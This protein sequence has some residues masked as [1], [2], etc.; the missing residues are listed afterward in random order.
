VLS[1]VRRNFRTKLFALVLAI[2]A[3]A[4][5]HFSAS[6]SI[7]AHFEQQ[8]SVP[9]VVSGLR[10]GFVARYTDKIALV[11]IDVPRNGPAIKPEEVQAVL[12]VNAH[13]EA[14]IFNVPVEIIAPNLQIRSLSPASVTLGLDRLEERSV[15]VAITYTGDERAGTVVNS[16]V[17]NPTSVRVRGV[18]AD[19]SRVNVVHL[20][21]PIPIKPT[22]LDAMVKPLAADASGRE[23]DAVEVSPNLVR[24][25]VQFVR[26]TGTRP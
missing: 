20:D 21:V 15:P 10:S 13:P 23:V 22:T 18:S 26:S 8:L 17:V 11:T 5:F 1:I 2:A 16:A 19:L 25:R 24:V 7:T 9:I 6:P 14:G 3:W 12:D 4:Y